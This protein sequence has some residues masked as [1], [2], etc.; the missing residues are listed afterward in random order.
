MYKQNRRWGG[1]FLLVEK[2]FEVHFIADERAGV[3][4]NFAWSAGFSQFAADCGKRQIRPQGVRSSFDYRF[5]KVPMTSVVFN[6]VVADVQGEP[7]KGDFVSLCRHSGQNYRA[8]NASIGV[9][10]AL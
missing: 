8:V 1:L 5:V 6:S 4:G 2:A 9:Q 10:L 7:L 3:V